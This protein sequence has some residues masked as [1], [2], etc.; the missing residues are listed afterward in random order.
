MWFKKN[1]LLLIIVLIGFLP[2]L[3]F[4]QALPHQVPSHWGISGQADATMPRAY[5]VIFEPL[6]NL[7]LFFLFLFIPKWDPK[8]ANYDKF[9]GTYQLMRY[10][11]HLFFTAL[12]VWILWSAVHPPSSPNSFSVVSILPSMIGILFIVLGN[13]TTRVRQNYFMGV[14]TPWALADEY[15]W[16]RTN[17]F[18]GKILVGIGVI[19]LIGLL[20]PTAYRFYFLLIPLIVGIIWIYVYSYLVFKNKSS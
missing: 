20:F 15:V 6:I 14:R 4:W 2:G 16:Q 17:R 1:G 19:T 5:A 11:I 3:L 10:L 7:V 8:K 18:G 13:Y 12:Q 9:S